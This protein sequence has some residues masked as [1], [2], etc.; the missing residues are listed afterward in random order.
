MIYSLLHLRLVNKLVRGRG[1]AFY[2]LAVWGF[3]VFLPCIPSRRERNDPRRERR[4]MKEANSAFD[5]TGKAF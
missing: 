3:P 4:A 2:R 1:Q 5:F